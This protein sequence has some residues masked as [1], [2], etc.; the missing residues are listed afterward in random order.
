MLLVWAFVMQFSQWIALFR[1]AIKSALC[2]CATHSCLSTIQLLIKLCVY[3][4]CPRSKNENAL[5]LWFWGPFWAD[6][7]HM[8]TT[9]KIN[10]EV[11]GHVTL[12]HSPS[13]LSVRENPE[14][15]LACQELLTLHALGECGWKTKRDS[16]SPLFLHIEVGQRINKSWRGT[17][18]LW[19]GVQFRPMKYKF[20]SKYFGNIYTVKTPDVNFLT[21]NRMPQDQ[22]IRGVENFSVWWPDKYIWIFIVFHRLW[23]LLEVFW[24]FP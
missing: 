5:Q 9:V 24:M 11:W 21:Y 4:H 13:P 20:V 2:G 23:G 10:N 12:Q 8:K 18:P 14:C 17:L 15:N 22:N 7:E 1:A 3:V 16:L 6:S 19:K